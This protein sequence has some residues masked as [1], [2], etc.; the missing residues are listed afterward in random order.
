MTVPTRLFWILMW[1][2]PL[3]WYPDI[4]TYFSLRDFF[5]AA[6]SLGIQLIDCDICLT[7]SNKWVQK[8]KK[9]KIKGLYMNRSTFWMIEYMYM[10]GS[11]FSKAKYMNGVG[12]EILAR[13]PVP[14]FPQSYTPPPPPHPRDPTS[15]WLYLRFHFGVIFQTDEVKT[16]T[17]RAFIR[18]TRVEYFKNK[19]NSMH[20]SI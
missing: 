2:V 14:Q 16:H 19:Y 10:N 15:A 1:K 4:C 18:Q 5:E 6:C 9:K 3:F 8:K 17:D 12:F 7:T 20:I 11:V 13:T